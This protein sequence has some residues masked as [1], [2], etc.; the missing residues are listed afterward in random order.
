M[1]PP[2][3]HP[4]DGAVASAQ[5]AVKELLGEG[6]DTLSTLEIYGRL[7]DTQ[8]NHKA[9]SRDQAIALF[10]EKCAQTLEAG[11]SL[12]CALGYYSAPGV[13]GYTWVSAWKR[14]AAGKVVRSIFDLNPNHDLHYEYTEAQWFCSVSP[15]TTEAIT[16]PFVDS[17]GSNEYR[18]TIARAVTGAEDGSLIGVIAADMMASMVESRLRQELRPIDGQC[19][20]VNSERRVIAANTARWPVGSLIPEDQLVK[21]L[22][23]RSANWGLVTAPFLP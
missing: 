4:V 19:A 21:D 6:L 7:A 8:T 3:T 22:G 20:L 14:N 23:I 15:Q 12:V 9:S 11:S 2:A 16:G 18:F 13:D 17:G 5:R 10:D 1:Q